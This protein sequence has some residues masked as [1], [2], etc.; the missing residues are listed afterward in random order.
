MIRQLASTL[1][2]AVIAFSILLISVS[3][4]ITPKLF[5]GD[6]PNKPITIAHNG[7]YKLPEVYITPRNIFWPF[8]ALHDKIW[9]MAQTNSQDL[10]NALLFLS[11]ERLHI[12]IDL[13]ED[14]DI[15]EAILAFRKAEKYLEDAQNSSP[16]KEG[17]SIS[18][19]AQMHM[20]ILTETLE[21]APEEA[22]PFVIVFMDVPKRILASNASI[23]TF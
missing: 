19:T 10:T 9:V 17:P 18:L 11:D 5:A 22:K 13:L 8:K 6:M 14:G 16:T 20:A 21:K 1:T 4:F 12:G 7:H 15:P 3:S 2:F 23:D